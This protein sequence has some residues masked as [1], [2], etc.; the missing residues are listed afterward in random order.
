MTNEKL[1]GLLI[2]LDKMER[3]IDDNGLIQAA[4]MA[5]A[6]LE[7]MLVNQK[8]LIAIC[9]E[10]ISDKLWQNGELEKTITGV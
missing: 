10:L 3:E 7:I 9:R 4:R 5:G 1:E 2:Q 8:G 6:G